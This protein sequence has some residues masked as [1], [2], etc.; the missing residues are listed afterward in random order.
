MSSDAQRAL[1]RAGAMLT[2][3]ALGLRQPIHTGITTG[4]LLAMLLAPVWLVRIRRYRGAIP[5]L[6]LGSAAVIAGQLLS[7]YSSDTNVVVASFRLSST[8]LLLGTLCTIGVVLWARTVLSG[9]AVAAWYGVGMLV[10]PVLERTPSQGNAWKFVFGLPVAIVVLAIAGRRSRAWEFVALAGLALTSIHFDSRSYFATLLLTGSVVLWQVR[11]RAVRRR[12]SAAG[13]AV[14]FALIGAATYFVGTT[15]LVNGYL[16]ADA[17][18]RSIAQIQT[19]GSLILGGRPELQATL[20]LFKERPLG[21]GMGVVANPHDVL[22]AKSGLTNVNYAPNNGYVDRYM[23]GNQIELH[24][25]LGDIWAQ[26]GV[27]GIALVAMLAYLITGGL[28]RRIANGTAGALLVFVSVWSLW[29]L[30]FSPFFASAPILAL[31]V[32]L[33]L[34]VKRG[35]A[36]TPPDDSQACPETA[37]PRR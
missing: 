4:F 36:G 27:L 18:S 14:V 26:A 16:G 6:L 19:S 23:F 1:E 34:T 12:A 11:P 24:S 13:T 25:V 3:F 28:V 2:L 33:G 7:A 9:S 37:R 22:V 20:A 15:L 29:C 35:G 10:G 32:G 31:A 17:Q 5:L 21:F 30:A 8:A